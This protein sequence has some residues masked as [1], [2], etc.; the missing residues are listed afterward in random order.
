MCVVIA[1][2]AVSG[3]ASRDRGT[4]TVTPTA[5]PSAYAS[6]TIAPNVSAAYSTGLDPSLANISSED[7]DSLPE[8]DIPTPS[9]E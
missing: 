2:L 1:G 7:N 8:L 5:V 9:A 4:P 6:P 3:C